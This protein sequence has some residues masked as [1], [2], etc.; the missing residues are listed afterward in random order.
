[1]SEQTKPAEVVDLDAVRSE[2]QAAERKRV[3]EITALARSHGYDAGKHV[4]A[5]DSVDAV[6][7]AILDAKLAAQAQTEVRGTHGAGVRVGKSHTEQVVEGIENAIAHRAAPK[8]QQIELTD[9]GRSFRAMSLGRMAETLLREQGV[10]VGM[11]SEREIGKAAMRIGAH[12]VSA[13]RSFP[14]AHTSGDFPYILANV[15][16]KFL[17]AGYGAEPMT[18]DA[19]SYTRSIRDL[20]Q[21]STVR[22]GSV[23]ALPKVVEGAEYTY[24]TIGEEREVYTVAKYGQILPFTLEMVINDDLSA[25]NMLAEEMGRA[26]GRTE[27]DLVYGSSGVFGSN[28]GAGEAMGDGNNLFDAS[29][30]DNQVGAHT[31][32]STSG[33]AAL[34]LLLR[35]Q[36]DVNGN[37][38]NLSPSI[39]LVPAAL[40]T[41]AEQILNGISMPIT[42]ATAQ[43]P[44]FRGLQLVVEPRIDDINNGTAAYY[45][46]SNRPWVELGKL[47]GYESPQFE[48][49]E[50]MDADQIGYKV[51]YFCAAK[52]TD[53][54]QVARDPGA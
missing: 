44:A 5:G 38:I 3:S 43:V 21:V 25:F 8:G 42:D 12:S 26:A 14:G 1:M 47:A 39:L 49:I 2:A 16:N 32:L 34:R 22:L 28:S 33:I 23:A 31:A 17:L 46:M 41:T 24:A 10:D 30:H 19:F 13:T 53:W 29:N 9:A 7:A 37:R 6:R 4:D 18:H 35:N 48:T 40:E 52:A 54:R 45:L 27:L 51:R 15:A 36:T 50:Q 11:M 20:K